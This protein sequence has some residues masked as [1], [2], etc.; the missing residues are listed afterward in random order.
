MKLGKNVARTP[1]LLRPDSSGA[2][3]AAGDK[4]RDEFVCPKGQITSGG[5]THS[6]S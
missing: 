5:R 3:L 6:N 2:C 1:C 4:G